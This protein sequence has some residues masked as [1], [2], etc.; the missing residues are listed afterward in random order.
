VVPAVGMHVFVRALLIALLHVAVAR[1]DER[2]AVELAA[3]LEPALAQQLRVAI[4]GQ[5]ADLA[6]V[7]WAGTDGLCRVQV[8]RNGE[9][10]SVVLSNGHERRVRSLPAED[11]ELAAGELA[12]VVRA[13]VIAQQERPRAESVGWSASAL[14][15]G[16]AYARELAWQSGVRAE[17][18]LAYRWLHVGAGYG[19]HPAVGVGGTLAKIRVRDHGVYAVLGAQRYGARFGYGADLLAGALGTMRTTSETPLSETD[20]SRYW[21]A[22]LALRLRGRVRVLGRLW[23][24]LMPALELTLGRPDYA[25]DTGLQTR[26]LSP[27]ALQG[28]LDVGATFGPR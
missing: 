5:L 8:A 21:N 9:E 13:Y 18:A 16:N 25:V 23:F 19:Y 26:V 10:L 28:R 11:T 7:D 12:S 2:V 24:E 6:R 27:R 3:E 15:S 1:A 14:Y 22:S 17:V 20:D 4:A